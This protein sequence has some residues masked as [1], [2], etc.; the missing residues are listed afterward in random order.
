MATCWL[1]K[2]E[3]SVYS[4]QQLVKDKKTVWDGVGN[5]LA[6]KNLKDI[7]KG[8]QIFIYHTG[9]EKAAVGVARALGGAYP[10][11]EKDKPNL[12]V[13]DIEPVR[14]LPKPVTLAQVKAHPKLKNFD[15]VRNSRLSIM[16]VT[17]EQWEIMEGMA[18]N[19]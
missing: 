12:L 13:V 19:K 5:N 8:E 11:P 2:T 16:K 15:L 17:D 10:D 9:D 1:F 7:K 18:K 6:L 3:P 14:A 4:Y